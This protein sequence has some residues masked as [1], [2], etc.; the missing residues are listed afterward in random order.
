MAAGTLRGRTS[1]MS[2]ES[3]RCSSASLNVSDL[4]NF[5]SHPIATSSVLGSANEVPSTGAHLD[6]FT[7]GKYH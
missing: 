5:N 4:N 1:P 7:Y 2:D 3:S 6:N